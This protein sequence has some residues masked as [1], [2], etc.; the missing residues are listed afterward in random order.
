[1]PAWDRCRKSST[2]TRLIV[3]L[4]ALPR[5]G[6][7]P[8]S[9]EQRWKTFT[10]RKSTRLNSSHSQISYAVFCLKKKNYFETVTLSW[11]RLYVF[12]AIEQAHLRIRVLGATTHPTASWMTQVAKNLVMSLEDA[13]FRAQ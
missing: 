13:C 10:D 12:P 4:A 3:R 7:W 5:L 11:A 8:R 6:A 2:A 9:Y 1:M